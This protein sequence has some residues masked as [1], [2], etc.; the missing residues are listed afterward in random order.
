MMKCRLSKCNAME[1][2]QKQTLL[3]ALCGYYPY[4]VWIDL[5]GV[6]GKM[7]DLRVTHLYNGTNTVQEIDASI[8]FFGDG[9]YIDIEHFKPILRPMES[10][11]AEELDEYVT[12]FDVVTFDGVTVRQ[13]TPNTYDWLNSHFFDY[14][15]LIGQNMAIAD[16][17]CYNG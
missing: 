8:D 12:T 17:N 15:N 5:D 7:N 11:T 16:K 6:S 1:L 14:R 3:A 2:K 4:G 9:D 10:M 13:N